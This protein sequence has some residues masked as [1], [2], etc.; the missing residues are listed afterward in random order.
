MKRILSVAVILCLASATSAQNNNREVVTR[1]KTT[2]TT[3]TTAVAG[4]ASYDLL[5]LETFN[6]LDATT[7]TEGTVDL[8]ISGRWI[9]NKHTTRTSTGAFREED[10]DD[11][12][13]DDEWLVIPTIV[14]GASERYEMFVTVPTWVSGEPEEGNYDT[15]VGGQ[16][17]IT[18]VD[19]VCPAVALGW[20]VR[21]PTGDGSNGVDAQLRLILTN[22][23]ESGIRSHLNLWA[24]TVN[25]DNVE[26]ARHFQYGGVAGLDGPLNDDGSLRW[27]LDYKYES[28]YRYG[29]PDED[30]PLGVIE[31]D[32]TSG[33]QR[34][35]AEAGLQ[36]VINDC[37][38][39]GFAVQ[40]GLDHAEN[41]TPEWGA[42]LTYAY[43]IGAR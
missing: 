18:D 30:T 8:R 23:H 42:S 38:K 27:V 37:H 39:L 10:E 17:R 12:E 25:T 2:V 26:D 16:W 22:E 14:W 11:D 40:A 3:T 33:E 6:F 28:S 24:T 19:E 36:W 41:E 7:L 31:G 9:E 5:G 35:S 21:V 13:D 4:P 20:M 34:N 29:D 32:D 15:Y 43:T 1:E